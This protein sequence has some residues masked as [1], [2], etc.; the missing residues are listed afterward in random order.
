MPAARPQSLPYRQF[1]DSPAGADQKQVCQVDRADQQERQG[2]ALHPQQRGANARDV[3]RAERRHH[4]P[5]AGVGEHLR[6]RIV[7]FQGIV[8]SV[9]L[10]LRLCQRGARFEA[11]DDVFRI[12]TRMPLPGH[13]IFGTRRKGKIQPRFRR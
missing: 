13:A 12:P 6:L 2:A 11:S 3:V 9:N 8:L 5:E 4:G 7:P 1:L 10:S